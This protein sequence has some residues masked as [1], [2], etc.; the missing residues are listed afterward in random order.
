MRDLTNKNQFRTDAINLY[1]LGENSPSTEDFALKA[2]DYLF[3]Q[4]SQVDGLVDA[5]AL[6]RFFRTMNFSDLTDDLKELAKQQFDSEHLQASNC[7]TLLASRGIQPEWNNRNDSINHRVIPLLSVEAVERAPMVA[8][9]V[10]RLGIEVSNVVTPTPSWFLPRD[11]KKYEVMYIA[12]AK[13]DPAIVAQENFVV[14][15]GVRSVIGYGGLLPTG[16]MFAVLMF[17]RIYI[18]VE[19]AMLFTSFSRAIEEALVEVK[20]GKRSRAKILVADSAKGIRRMDNLLGQSHELIST[21]TVEDAVKA[22]SSEAFDLIVCGI[23]FDDSRMFDL[24][25]AVK[26]DSQTK[27]K[28]FICVRQSASPLGP[29]IDAGLNTAATLAGAAS[30][31]DAVKMSDSDLVSALESYLPEEI[32]SV[33]L[34]NS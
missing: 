9:L 5:C 15:F 19:S 3:D 13:D 24:L 20:S 33:S 34:L 31:I 4:F 28:P 18:P 7:L 2:T 32:W 12:E 17:M 23:E 10:S 30:V 8:R 26:T 11:Q 6:V 16:D 29:G 1:G 21:A 27:P 22:L 14:P 25:K